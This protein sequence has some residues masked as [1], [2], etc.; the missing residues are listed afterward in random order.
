MCQVKVKGKAA[1]W[2]KSSSIGFRMTL[3]GPTQAEKAF[4]SA[5]ELRPSVLERSLSSFLNSEI[6]RV[7]NTSLSFAQKTNTEFGM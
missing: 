4:K 2:V 1:E 7:R 5:L 3:S 6:E